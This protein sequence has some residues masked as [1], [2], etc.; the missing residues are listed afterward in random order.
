MLSLSILVAF[1]L[2]GIYIKVISIFL[3]MIPFY[4]SLLAN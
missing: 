1:L 4:N 2:L 3:Y